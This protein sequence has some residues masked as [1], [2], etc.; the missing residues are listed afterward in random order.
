MAHK[1]CFNRLRRLGLATIPALLASS[2]ALPATAAD[3]WPDRPIRL[4]VNFAPGGAA[5]VMGRAISPTMSQ[6]L[7]QSVVVDNKPGANG[8]IGI[9]ETVRAPKD[10]YTLLLSSGGGISINPLIYSKLPFN[11]E[12]DLIP[13]AAVARVH[14]FLETSPSLPVSNVQDFVK[15]LQANPGKLSYGS[16]GPGSSPHLAGEMFKRAAKVDAIHVPY[17]GAG[18]ALTDVLS[19]QLQYWFDPGPGLKQVEAGKLKLLAIGSPHRS[20]LYPKVPTLAESGL[21]GFDADTLFGI[22]APAGTPAPVVEAVRASVIKAL[23]QKNVVEVIQGLGATPEPRM[24]RQDFVDHHAK[25]RA[26]FAPLIKEIG[27]K[28]D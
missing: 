4:I 19:G 17:K 15:Y 13:V 23:E 10:G 27:L 21:P 9:G 14:V 20:P 18:P 1:P 28:V 24:S 22:Y 25:E 16:P 12:K 5:D 6:E 11:P 26:R 2:F 3:K 7:G 8:N